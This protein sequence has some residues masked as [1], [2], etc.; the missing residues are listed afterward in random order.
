MPNYADGKIYKI[1]CDESDLI[2]IGSTCQT[3]ANRLSQHKNKSN[4]K[5]CSKE[6]FKL[7]NCSI[8]LIEKFPCKDKDELHARE[9]YYIDQFKD[10]CINKQKA[11][12]GI[13]A[14]SRK[15]YAEQYEQQYTETRILKYEENRN[16]ILQKAKKYYEENK[17]IIKERISKY[18]EQNKDKINQKMKQKLICECSGQY[19]RMNKARHEKTQ[20]H[21]A[22]IES[23]KMTE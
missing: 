19:L 23:N 20:K 18:K 15:D 17:D 7:G 8:V 5:C 6:L 4:F 14:E 9:Q 10:K 1:I 12:T 21:I 11:S 3:L 16:E 2:Y 13:K 22:F